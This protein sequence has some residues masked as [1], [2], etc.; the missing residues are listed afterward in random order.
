MGS[1]ESGR[2]DHMIVPSQSDGVDFCS[3]SDG[4]DFCSQSDG[5]DLCRHSDGDASSCEFEND[6]WMSVCRGAFTKRQSKTKII[7]ICLL[8]HMHRYADDFLC[9]LFI[10]G[11]V[12]DSRSCQGPA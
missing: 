9:G 5:V 1:S 12:F 6:S 8:V 3:Q 10:C 2:S 4:V 7:N 11:A